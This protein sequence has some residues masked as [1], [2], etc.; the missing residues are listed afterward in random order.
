M[1]SS[2]SEDFEPM[3]IKYLFL[4]QKSFQPHT[5]WLER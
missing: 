1:I 5:V 3:L 4:D 2:V